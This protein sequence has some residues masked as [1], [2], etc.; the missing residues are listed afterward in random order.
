ML[1]SLRLVWAARRISTLRRQS[2][3]PE[4]AVLALVARLQERMKLARPV[5][6][7]ITVA[8]DCP[9]VVGWIRPALL[10][11]A[12][13]IIGLTPQQLEAVLAHELAHILRY[14][15]VANMLQTVVET[16]LFYHPAVWW[17]SGRMRQEREL[18][19]DD[20]AVA[21]CGDA[22]CYARALTRL[23]RLRVSAPGLA[24][25]A[26]GSTGGPLLYRIRRIMGEAA[27]GYTPSKLP[28][29]LALSVGLLCLAANMQW[30]RG[31]QQDAPAGEPAAIESSTFDDP[32]VRVDLRGATVLHRDSVAYPEAALEKGVQ[33]TV[34][35]EATL[36]A[37]GMV[38]DARVLSGPQ[39]LRKTALESV[40]QWHFT[41]A[42]AGS[43]RQI[44]VTFE[45]P[46][47]GAVPRSVGPRIGPDIE[48]GVEGGVTGGVVVRDAPG[49]AG[50]RLALA[51]EQ[52]AQQ[53]AQAQ[54]LLLEQQLRKQ[55][56]IQRA[57]ESERS[58][59]LSAQMLA[60]EA[61]L[62]ALRQTYQEDHPD[63][64]KL[65]AE[66]EA[67]HNQ[68]ETLG[69]QSQALEK[70]LEEA[71]NGRGALED[72]ASA[73]A[74]AQRF[75]APD[76]AKRLAEFQGG[77]LNLDGHIFTA[78]KVK[79]ITVLGFTA[80]V[81][82]ELLSKLPVNAGDTLTS[83]SFEKI[84]DAVKQFDEHLSVSLRVMRDGQVDIRIAAPGTFD[85]W[86]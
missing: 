15:Y 18:C 65:E 19:C 69:V 20:L 16:L 17:V 6:V 56:A 32:G 44:D 50:A 60:S 58:S 57:I 37:K 74:D 12:A 55:E 52:A 33:G 30:A 62:Q 43:A 68:R 53:Q 67:L 14:D 86:D 45:K 36:D 13:T 10:L 1:F 29:I 25:L 21:A 85:Q 27:Q 9:S 5:R 34:V 39:E 54:K 59:Q 49:V 51:L 84:T 23:E 66:L 73:L 42:A 8:A 61:Q 71:A 48:G 35:V 76:L 41:H 63:V 2:E 7:M 82:E 80:P 38:S 26:L 64:R 83:E 81:R 75:Q 70:R 46:L 40:L 24:G 72:A 28:G 47:E 31:Q 11:P 4:A 22:L 79:S 77:M 3:R 78:R